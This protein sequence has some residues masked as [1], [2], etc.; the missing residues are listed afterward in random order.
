MGRGVAVAEPKPVGLHAVRSQLG[1]DRK[2]FI[3]AAPTTFDADA[4]AEG[5]HH[6]VQVGADLQSKKADV[7]TGIGDNGDFGIRFQG[8]EMVQQPTGESSPPD[9]ASQ[10]RDAHVLIL[11]G[12][13]GCCDL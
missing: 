5:V 10:Q 7:I 13:P 11:S 6:G 2:G 8:R 1:L 9:A 3:L 12:M 4:T